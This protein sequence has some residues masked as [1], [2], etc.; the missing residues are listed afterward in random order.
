MFKDYRGDFLYLEAD[1]APLICA[2][3]MKIKLSV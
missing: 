2:K 1:V 3:S